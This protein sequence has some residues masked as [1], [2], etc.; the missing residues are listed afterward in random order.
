MTMK[1]A[2]FSCNFLVL[3]RG[4]E[5]RGGEEEEKSCKAGLAAN[6]DIKQ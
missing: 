1:L 3:R 6:N 2:P 4:R 5:N